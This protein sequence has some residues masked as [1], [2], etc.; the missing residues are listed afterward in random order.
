MK[1]RSSLEPSQAAQFLAIHRELRSPHLLG[2]QRERLA[3]AECVAL[4]VGVVYV[5]SEPVVE[6]VVVVARWCMCLKWD[7]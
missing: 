6:A 2:W 3:V 4:E 1:F 5:G 7:C